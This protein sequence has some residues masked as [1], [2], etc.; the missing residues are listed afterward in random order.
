MIYRSGVTSLCMLLSIGKHGLGPKKY[1]YRK[2][3]AMMTCVQCRICCTYL[4]K[5]R[6]LGLRTKAHPGAVQRW[7]KLEVCPENRI[8][9]CDAWGITLGQAQKWFYPSSSSSSRPVAS[10][11]SVKNSGNDRWLKK[12]LS[13]TLALPLFVRVRFNVISFAFRV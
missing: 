12:G 5:T 7:E 10:K 9:L 2:G 6:C 4:P 8:A 11:H 3:D 13:L 1:Q